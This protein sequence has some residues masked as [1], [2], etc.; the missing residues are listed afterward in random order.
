MARIVQESDTRTSPRWAGDWNDRIHLLPGGGKVDAA[1]FAANAQGRKPVPSGT[2]LGRTNAERDAGNPWGPAADTDD[3]ICLL[4]FD[5]VDAAVNPECEIYRPL[6]GG[7][8]KLQ[9]LPAAPSAAVLAK[10]RAA[11]NVVKGA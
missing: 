1:A 10:L 2:L 9:F 4:A 8:V 6:V 11:Y 3:E 5:I 7:V